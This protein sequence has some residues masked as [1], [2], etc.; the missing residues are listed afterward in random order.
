MN[1]TRVIGL[2][3]FLAAA[4]AVQAFPSSR[5]FAFPSYGNVPTA[6]LSGY[7][8]PGSTPLNPPWRRGLSSLGTSLALLGAA[9]TL[10]NS[11]RWNNRK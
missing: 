3:L 8:S 6:T 1:K 10:F 9:L 11:M 2:V 5:Q 7:N 4:S